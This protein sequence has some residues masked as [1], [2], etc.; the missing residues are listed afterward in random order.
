LDCH[1]GDIRAGSVGNPGAWAEHN[2][3]A[4]DRHSGE[5]DRDNAPER[6]FAPHASAV[7]DLIGVERHG[8][9]FH[10]KPR[11]GDAPL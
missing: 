3:E 9:S 6:E 5:E 4:D 2:R 1:P 7:N 10:V 8:R 11:I